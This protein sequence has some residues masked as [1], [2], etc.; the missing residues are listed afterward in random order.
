MILPPPDMRPPRRLTKKQKEFE[1]RKKR[2]TLI[3]AFLETYM[4]KPKRKK[5]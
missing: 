3:M 5:K 4:V 2:G 1:E